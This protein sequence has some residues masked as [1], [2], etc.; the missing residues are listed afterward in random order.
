MNTNGNSVYCGR[1]GKDLFAK[2]RHRGDED[3]DEWLCNECWD[4]LE[5]MTMNNRS[6]FI[7]LGCNPEK[8]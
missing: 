2:E 3:W 7:S 4:E 1:C 5:E 6:I 8:W